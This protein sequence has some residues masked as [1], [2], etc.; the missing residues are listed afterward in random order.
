[1]LKRPGQNGGLARAH[2]IALAESVAVDLVDHEDGRHVVAFGVE[3]FG[4]RISDA[5]KRRT[6]GRDRVGLTRGA[7]RVRE[8]LVNS[9]D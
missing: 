9:V 2:R 5:L 4:R 6:A 3:G 1:M 8:V 7:I